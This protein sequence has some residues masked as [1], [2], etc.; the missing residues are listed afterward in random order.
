MLG[1]LKVIKTQLQ[2]MTLDAVAVEA[3]ILTSD[4]A[5]VLMVIQTLTLLNMFYRILVQQ[6][7]HMNLK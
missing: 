2:S 4:M 7:S 5:A 6:I 1:H 3:S